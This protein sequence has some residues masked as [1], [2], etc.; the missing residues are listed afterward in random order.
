MGL[1]L[2]ALSSGEGCIEQ[3]SLLIDAGADPDSD[4]GTCC[5]AMCCAASVGNVPMMAL[6]HSKGACVDC[7]GFAPLMSASADNEVEAAQWLVDRGADV[8][9]VSLVPTT[10]GGTA[11]TSAMLTAAKDGHVGLLQFLQAQ[12]AL[13]VAE[14]GGQMITALHQAATKGQSECVKFILGC[15]FAVDTK[16]SNG[17]TALHINTLWSSGSDR[18]A[19]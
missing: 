3:I 11:P 6:L 9:R 4:V 2:L 15:G 5:S 13:F 18:A 10:S 19:A 12:G 14:A 8:A 17:A 1:S 16:D 7:E